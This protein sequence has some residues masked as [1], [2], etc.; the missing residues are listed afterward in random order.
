MSPAD[1]LDDFDLQ[2]ALLRSDGGDL[3]TAVEVLA[4]KL[5]QAL[6]GRTTVK[7]SGGGLLGKGRKQVRQVL[8]LLGETSYRLDVDGEQ[9]EG[10]RQ[11]QVGGIA[12]KRETLDPHRWLSELTDALRAEAQRSADL[13]TALS[14]LIG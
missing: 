14:I 13:R 10:F 6:P 11:R 9:I 5:E 8:V 4:S 3:L 2:A 7:R 1:D 12:I